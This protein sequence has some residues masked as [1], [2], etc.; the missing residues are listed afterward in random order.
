E[1]HLMEDFKLK[2]A[3][4]N[5]I[6]CWNLAADGRSTTK[7]AKIP[8]TKA[9]VSEKDFLRACQA[10]LDE[11][12]SQASKDHAKTIMTF[13]DETP[14]AAVVITDTEVKGF[15]KDEKREP[16]LLAAYCAGNVQSQLHSGVVRN[17]RYSGLL[18]L[19]KTYRALQAAD[20]E[21][22]IAAVE[23]LLKL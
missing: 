14:K 1:K 12:L 13:T 5:W 4:Q 21:F 18:Y 7:P 11:P 15:G 9:T 20:K 22:K 10:L 16:L 8:S 6:V 23:E 17:D 3:E 2:R 19:F